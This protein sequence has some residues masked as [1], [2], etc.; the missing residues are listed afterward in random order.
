M[1]SGSPPPPSDASAWNRS[2][3]KMTLTNKA[4]ACWY[5]VRK[6]QSERCVGMLL[7]LRIRGVDVAVKVGRCFSRHCPYVVSSVFIAAKQHHN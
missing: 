5:S 2:G 4:N 6:Q 1:S 3:Q 7:P